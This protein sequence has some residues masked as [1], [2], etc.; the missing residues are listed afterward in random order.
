MSIKEEKNLKQRLARK[1]NNNF[2]TKK[3]EK[4]KKGKLMRTYRNMKSR[5]EG[6]LKKK[7]HLY[8]GLDILDKDSFY[9]WSLSNEDFHRLFK[10]WEESGYNLKLSPSIEREDTSIGYVEGNI[11]WITHSENSRNGGKWSALRG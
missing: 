1:A 11:R 10:D 7:S 9:L 6:I 5:V 8:E 3:Y 4:T 2:H